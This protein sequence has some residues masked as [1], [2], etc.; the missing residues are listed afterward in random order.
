MYAQNSLDIP[1]H[2]QHTELG[3]ALI[4]WV[5][6]DRRRRS[7]M[8]SPTLRRLRHQVRAWTRPPPRLR[9]LDHPHMRHGP[10]QPPKNTPPRRPRTHPPPHPRPRLRHRSSVALPRSGPST[11]ITQQTDDLDH[12]LIHAALEHS[13]PRRWNASPATPNSS[14]NKERPIDAVAPL[15][16][17]RTPLPPPLRRQGHHRNRP[18][19]RTSRTPPPRSVDTIAQRLHPVDKAS[20]GSRPLLGP[21]TS[22]RPGRTPPNRPRRPRHRHPHRPQTSTVDVIVD[23]HVLVERA[24]AQPNSATASPSAAKPPDASL[25]RPPHRHH[26][27]RWERDPRRRKTH[28]PLEPRPTP[29]HP[30]PPPPPPP[31]PPP[32]RLPRLRPP[33]HPNPPHPTLEPSRH[34]QPRRRHS[35]LLEPPPPRPRSRAGHSLPTHHRHH[36]LHRTPRPEVRRPR[37]AQTGPRREH[38]HLHP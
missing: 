23:Y 10:H 17:P 11:R 29:R 14:T 22:R 16:T 7:R 30:L 2:C 21:T 15:A 24:P 27:Q 36:H 12:A 8:D 4:P 18:A 25:R 33:H 5:G 34:H 28:P 20:A 9:H 13:G 6:A 19:R 1:T 35:T 26:R 38:L 3:E 31:P 32:M 37:R